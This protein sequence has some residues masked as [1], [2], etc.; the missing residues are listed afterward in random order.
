MECNPVRIIIGE[1]TPLKIIASGVCQLI[2]NMKGG[3]GGG[4]GGDVVGKVC[5]VVH[6]AMPLSSQ[7]FYTSF[8]I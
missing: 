6:I 5:L 7:C 2:I 1:E 3:G 8:L 4:G